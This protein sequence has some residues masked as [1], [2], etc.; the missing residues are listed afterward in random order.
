LFLKRR[1]LPRNTNARRPI[2]SDIMVQTLLASEYEVAERSARSADV[3]IHPDLSGIQW[4]E[5]YKVDELIRRGE[6]AAEK[7]LVQIKAMVG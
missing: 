2:I 5:L 6:E 4:Y 7:A 1:L 3:M